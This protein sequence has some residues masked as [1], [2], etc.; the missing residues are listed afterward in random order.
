MQNWG[1]LRKL[2]DILNSTRS[3]MGKAL[4]ILHALLSLFHPLG[5]VLLSDKLRLDPRPTERDESVGQYHCKPLTPPKSPGS[6]ETGQFPRVWEGGRKRGQRCQGSLTQ[7]GTTC[8]S[9]L[10]IHVST[11]TSFGTKAWILY[12]L[13]HVANAIWPRSLIPICGNL[14]QR[15]LPFSHGSCQNL[16]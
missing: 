13:C 15:H 9:L 1:G 2:L 14:V 12:F 3:K 4:S 7:N 8:L 6:G 11:F 16:C 5:R 10:D